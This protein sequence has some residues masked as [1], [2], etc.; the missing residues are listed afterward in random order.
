MKFNRR[1]FIPFFI[2]IVFSVGAFYFFQFQRPQDPANNNIGNSD[3]QGG[4]ESVSIISSACN[5]VTIIP[6]P[7]GFPSTRGLIHMAAAGTASGPIGY[8]VDLILV[9]GAETNQDSTIK[10]DCGAWAKGMIGEESTCVRE[11]GDPDSTTWSIEANSLETGL[12][13]LND[14]RDSPNSAN[15]TSV[16]AVIVP[17]EALIDRTHIPQFPDSEQLFHCK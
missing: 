14:W 8:E 7:H 4:E 9:S 1:V 10:L 3:V 11:E 5:I 16:H 12:E 6:E 13:R 2:I 17:T 15:L